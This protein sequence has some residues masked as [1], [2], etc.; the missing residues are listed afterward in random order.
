M[1]QLRTHKKPRV[2]R[3]LGR[4]AFKGQFVITLNRD[5]DARKYK[6]VFL[7]IFEMIDAARRYPTRK[8]VS[9]RIIA[10]IQE[11]QDVSLRQEE[12]LEHLRRAVIRL[13]RTEY[14]PWEQ[15]TITVQSLKKKMCFELTLEVQR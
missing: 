13:L 2:T 15:T 14:R 5:V 6:Y 12:W 7:P 1:D 4:K 9:V 10:Q 8:K 11:P 3:H